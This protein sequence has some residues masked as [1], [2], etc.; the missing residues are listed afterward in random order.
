MSR[1]RFLNAPPERRL[2]R[3]S[4]LLALAVSLAISLSACGSLTGSS[5]P[6]LCPPWPEPGAE[7]AD[8]IEDRMFPAGDYPA[9]WHWLDRLD[10]LREQLDSC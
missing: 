1:L 4:L 10:I 3:L 8:E 5:D 2:V 6:S 9:F 7:V